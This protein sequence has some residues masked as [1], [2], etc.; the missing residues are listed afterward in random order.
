[1]I[2]AEGAMTDGKTYDLAWCIAAVEATGGDL[3]KAKEWL[4]NWAPAQ[5]EDLRA[6]GSG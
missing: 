1:M 2:A 4:E 6:V 3:E 5:G